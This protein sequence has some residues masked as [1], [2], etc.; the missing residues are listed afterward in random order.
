MVS[1]AGS[2]MLAAL[3]SALVNPTVTAASFSLSQPRAHAEQGRDLYEFSASGRRLQ[4]V[5]TDPA[6]SQAFKPFA[7]I[8]TATLD[9]PSVVWVWP[10]L[11]TAWL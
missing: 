8:N 9:G 6:E 4:A 11:Q 7:S 10:G 3:L 1:W 2:L 5:F